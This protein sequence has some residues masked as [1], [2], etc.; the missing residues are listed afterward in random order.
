MPIACF[1][2]LQSQKKQLSHL[3]R[4]ITTIPILTTEVENE[5]WHCLIEGRVLAFIIIFPLPINQ[6]WGILQGF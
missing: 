1:E 3:M 2:L 6:C 5:A 4:F